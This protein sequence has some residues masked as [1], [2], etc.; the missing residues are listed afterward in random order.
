MQIAACP[1]RPV[2]KLPPGLIPSK[3]FETLEQNQQIASC[4]R[5]P[6]HHEIEA[7]RSSADEP[8]PDIYVFHCSCGRQHRRFMIGGGDERP[9]WDVR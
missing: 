9:F 7:L 2:A 3:F 8:L 5:H 6:E 4:C 1:R